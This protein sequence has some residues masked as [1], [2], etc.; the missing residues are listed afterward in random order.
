MT[1]I[2]YSNGGFT[3]SE[4]MNLT[5][6]QFYEY[7]DAMEWCLNNE[8]K[9]GKKRNRKKEI[10]EGIE[11]LTQNDVDDIKQKV[12]EYKRKRNL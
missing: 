6:T 8:T 3:H 9:E 5:F 4:I 7:L 11:Q 1:L 10:Q 12:A 2:R